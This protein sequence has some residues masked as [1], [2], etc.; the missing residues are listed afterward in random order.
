MSVEVEHQQYAHQHVSH[1]FEDIE[2][3]N[4][5]YIVGMWTFLVTEIMFFGALFLALTIYRSIHVAD[6][7]DAHK[8][9]NVF[10]GGFNTVVLLTSSFSM[11]LAVRS[12]ML[13][14]RRGT[15][16]FL[17]LTLIGAF[18]FLGVK[19]IEYKEKWDLHLIPGP[20]FH[21]E[22][23]GAENNGESSAEARQR[24][25]LGA[26]PGQ[27]HERGPIVR[28]GG[29]LS[30][31]SVSSETGANTGA[32]NAETNKKGLAED[33][34]QLFFCLYFIMTGLHAIHIILGILV[35][36]ALWVMY[37]FRHPAVEDY[38][39]LEM[40]GLY[41]HFVDIVW[42]FLFPI[43]YLVGGHP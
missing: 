37:V 35:M 8:H 28:S 13:A 3:Q 17:G 39:T 24:T 22:S 33:G 2:Q 38:M 14:S 41:W 34:K 20:T 25:S 27:Y 9:L 29:D 32:N 4:E 21:Y 7:N 42:I 40:T 30:N 18:I 19:T 5:A 12:A 6:F 15:L 26:G 31:S 10:Y 16:F 11:V 23:V 36:G 43:L 1:Q